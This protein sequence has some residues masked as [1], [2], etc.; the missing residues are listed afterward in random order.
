MDFRKS[1]PEEIRKAN[2]R[3]HKKAIAFGKDERAENP[4]HGVIMT[5][6][7]V[8][9]LAILASALLPTALNSLTAVNSSWGAGV[10]ST[11]TALPVI[12]VLVVLV[13]ALG[14]AYKAVE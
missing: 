14:L 11:Y 1:I 12:I 6:I 9:M 3:L 4:A 8:F 13:S 7:G 10:V 2:I 5:I